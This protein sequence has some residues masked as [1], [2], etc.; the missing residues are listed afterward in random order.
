MSKLLKQ[1]EQL[2]KD[3]ASYIYLY[4]WLIL[5]LAWVLFTTFSQSRLGPWEFW[6]VMISIRSPFWI[7]YSMGT[8][9]PFT[10]APT[11]LFPTALCTLYAKSIGV[12]PFGRVFTS[13]CGVKQYTLSAN[14]S[15]SFFRRLMNSLL[16]GMSLCHSRI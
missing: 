2:K 13:P 1:Y 14:R 4:H 5:F 7:L 12:E 9:L 3:D 10:R 8:S 6:E 11:I 15:R 16:S